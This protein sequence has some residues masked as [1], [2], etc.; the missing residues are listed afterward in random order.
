MEALTHKNFKINN[1][2]SKLMLPDL[3]EFIISNKA[4]GQEIY[5]NKS[6]DVTYINLG[7]RVI[8]YVKRGIWSLIISPSVLLCS[9]FIYALAPL[10]VFKEEI[11]SLLLYRLNVKI[12]RLLDMIG[13]IICLLLCSVIFPIISLLIKLDSKGPVFYMQIRVGQNRRRRNRRKINAD[14]YTDRR[15]KDRRKNNLYGKP[16]VIYKFRTMREDAEKKC[17]PVWASKNDPRITPLGRILRYTHLDELPQLINILKGE[18]SFVGPRPER[19]YFVAQLAAKIPGYLE[20]LNVKPG[21]TGLAQ[22]NC[23]YDDSVESVVN[24]LKYDL[25]YNCN[26]SPYSYVKI[27]FMTIVKTILG[28][29]KI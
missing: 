2:T 8:I 14:I 24:K 12:K 28:K 10:K 26:G 5:I 25:H 16:F 21:L 4:F 3:E 18:M 29:I 9:L 20:R 19:P 27:L 11:K 1:I 17:G 13:A 6:G 23:G 7:N 22:I 15:N